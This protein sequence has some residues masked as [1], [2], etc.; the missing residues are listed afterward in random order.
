MNN[1][2][3]QQCSV[4]PMA[5]RFFIL[6]AVSACT[7]PPAPQGVTVSYGT[8]S[9]GF[10]RNGVALPRHGEGYVLARPT[11]PTRFG[12]PELVSALRRAA[13]AVA[14]EYPG[15]S[16][17]RVG[18][19]S[20]PSG[21]RHPRHGSHRSGRDADLIF[22]VTD[23]AG[24]SLTGRGWLRYDEFG[25]ARETHAPAG[26]TPSGRTF[27]FDAPR[28]WLFVRTLLLDPEANVQWLFCSREVKARLLDY[29]IAT[30]S[31]SEAIL[32]ASYVLHQ[33]SRGNPHAD[34]FHLRVACT[35][36]QR[37]FGCRDYGPVWPWIRKGIEKLDVMPVTSDEEAVRFLMEPRSLPDN[38]YE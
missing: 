26:V 28:N 21:G 14:R 27:H 8:P 13:A 18:D 15:G 30:E 16:P 32:R 23:E 31:S 2:Y 11:D 17:L 29:A 34:H 22:Y 20:S 35:A 5:V 24:H 6:L 33:P 3:I 12:T 10:L 1:P 25:T 37:A 36:E 19:L 7:G 4:F 38:P 9:R